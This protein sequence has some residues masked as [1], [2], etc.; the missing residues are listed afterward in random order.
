MS[1]ILP[2]SKSRKTPRVVLGLCATT[3]AGVLLAACA[4]QINRHG[5]VFTEVDLEQVQPGMSKD[6]VKL[7]L[8]T[9]DTTSTIGGD[10]YYY[11]QSTSETR[12]M[13][14]PKIVDRKI[15]A[16]YFDQSEQV[17]QLANYGLKDGHVFDFLS[18]TTP[19]R[20]KEVTFLEQMFGNIGNRREYAKQLA[21]DGG[22]SG[23]NIPGGPGGP[24]GR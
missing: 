4:P 12:P 11:I 13:G 9:P 3:L 21:K 1:P 20:G 6:Q 17:A 7:S 10:A 16:V 5:H 15:V 23:P 24:P 19:S 14:K 18:K 2:C 8:G 22:E